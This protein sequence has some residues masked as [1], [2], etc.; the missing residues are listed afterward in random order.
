MSGL[1]RMVYWPREHALACPGDGGLLT[2][3]DLGKGTFTETTAHQ[4]DFYAV[5]VFG[6]ELLTVGFKEAQLKT[7]GGELENPTY[8]LR[9]PSGVISAG[10]GGCPPA[11]LLLIE[12]RGAA[13]TWTL[14][15]GKLRLSHQLAGQDYRTVCCPGVDR[16]QMVYA[17][18]RMEEVQRIVT[19][20]REHS[21]HVDDDN[22]EELHARLID[23]DCEHVSLALRADQAHQRGNI[24]QAVNLYSSLMRILPTDDPNSC[25]SM[26]RYAA[27][28]GKAWQIPE[29]AKVCTR[30]QKIDPDYQLTGQTDNLVHL[31]KIF[32]DKQWV[33]NPSM[34]IEDIIESASAIGKSF[35]GRYVINE[36]RPQVCG[37]SQLEAAEI[38]EKYEQVRR[39][40][41][42][43]SL[44][45]AAA[46]RVWWLS[47]AGGEEIGLVSFGEGRT[48]T[49]RGLQLALQVLTTG[50]KTTVILT[51]LFDWR[52]ASKAVNLEA[53]NDQA[54]KALTQIRNRTL[55][56][57]YLGGIHKALQHCLQRLL[58]ERLSYEGPR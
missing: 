26:E 45:P 23:L 41:G 27:M 6:E 20:I 13:S 9:A 40:T 50:S 5:S 31:A 49:I 53:Q 24:V 55:S 29:A 19:K 58:T 21:A 43:T 33:V 4:G 38:V 3:Y 52:D 44:P 46:E 32:H 48:N 34:P 30:I 35:A 57:S 42:E 54:H 25:A 47:E 56:N 17:Q 12:A 28:L 11:E 51:V 37:S 15:A 14:Q 2:L 36:R 22:T 8:S 16:V 1:V 39:E 10:V 18:Q 7:W